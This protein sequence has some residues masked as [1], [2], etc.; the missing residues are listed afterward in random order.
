MSVVLSVS[1]WRAMRGVGWSVLT[2]SDLL[3]TDALSC[4]LLEGEKFLCRADHFTRKM[5]VDTL[6]LRHMWLWC[7]D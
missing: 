6:D 4:H 2:A 1:V 3:V 7:I 5:L